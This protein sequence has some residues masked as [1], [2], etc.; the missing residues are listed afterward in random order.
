MDRRTIENVIA[1]LSKERFD[2]LADLILK[3]AFVLK[4]YNVDGPYDGGSDRAVYADDGGRRSISFQL[5][6]QKDWDEKILD[7]ARKSVGKLRAQ[8]YFA[9]VSQHC[10][11]AKRVQIESEITTK[12]GVS[13]TLLSGRDI[14]EFVKDLQLEEELLSIAGMYPKPRR[15][16]SRPD[17]REMMLYGYIVLGNDSHSLRESIYDDTILL[18]LYTCDESVLSNDEIAERVIELLDAGEARRPLVKRR[19]DSL[20]AR[21]KVVRDGSRFRLSEECFLELQASDGLYD[22]ELSQLAN[23]Q[24]AV[25]QL[26]PDV[27]WHTELAQ[28]AANATARAFLWKQ[29][30]D[31]FGTPKVS[32]GILSAL[33]D[34]L[35]DLRELLSDKLDDPGSLEQT[36][37]KLVALGADQPIVKK[38]TRCAL[39]VAI[40]KLRQRFGV[41]ALGSHDWSDVRVLLESSV[42]IPFIC[43]KFYKPTTGRFSTSALASVAALQEHGAE[44][45]LPYFYLDECA[46]HLLRALQYNAVLQRFEK[47]LLHSRNGFVSTFLQLRRAREPVPETLQEFVATF[48]RSAGMSDPNWKNRVRRVMTD[49]QPLFESYAIGFEKVDDIPVLLRDDLHKQYTNALLDMHKH[50]SPYLVD[51][52]VRVLAHMVR[53]YSEARTQMICLTWDGAMIKV[54]RENGRCGCVVTPEV[55]H[56]FVMESDDELLGRQLSLV[57]LLSRSA[58]AMD[59]VGA[60]ILDRIVSLVH[61]ELAD[62]QFQQAIED[63]KNQM[64]GRIDLKDPAFRDAVETETDAFLQQRGV[65][66]AKAPEVDEETEI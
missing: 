66:L 43:A 52:D 56:D 48:S 61:S 18:A 40:E 57:H 19:L 60:V 13:A 59:T 46:A 45:R 23:Q 27:A 41:I 44:L 50:K 29:L 34:P 47:D 53:N 39:F 16:T 65:E 62:W 49:L 51:N 2:L 55:A 14:A 37:Q 1:A 10:D 58:N 15:S 5:T 3:R 4:P 21:G 36:I 9:L 54:A 38:L 26:K 6:V 32:I 42:A 24:A 12:L 22:T 31:R 63:F 7:D 20:A 8:R 17:L 11:R 35:Q 64:L 33:G 25:L 30:V 28:K